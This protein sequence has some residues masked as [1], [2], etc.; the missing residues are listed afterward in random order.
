M[1][2]AD[3]LIGCQPGQLG[4]LSCGQKNGGVCVR[5]GGGVE[6]LQ[7]RVQTHRD[8]TETRQTGGH[9]T[10][11]SKHDRVAEGWREGIQDRGKREQAEV[12]RVGGGLD[13]DAPLLILTFRSLC[14][15]SCW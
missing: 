11:T 13:A 3:L 1:F 8:Q 5:E 15:M 6:P 7:Q 2:V 14:T 12:K 10:G 9:K 4:H